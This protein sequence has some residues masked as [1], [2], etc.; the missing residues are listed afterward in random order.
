MELDLSSQNLGAIPTV[1]LAWSTEFLPRLAAA[2]IIL[3]GGMILARWISTLVMR[4]LGRATGLDVTVQPVITAVVRYAVVVLV[5]ILALGQLGVQ[6]A[7]LLAVLGAAGLAIGLSLQGTL[8]NIAAGIMLLWL[9]PFRVGDYIEV[10]NQNL[11]GTVREIGLFVCH[12]E[13]YDGVYLFAPN[14]T[15][16][17][18][19]LRNHSRAHARLVSLLV[20]LPHG[21]DIAVGTK[22]VQEAIK[23]M[24]Q[25]LKTPAPAIFVDSVTGDG[26]VLNC[27][28]W[29]KHETLGQVQRTIHQRIQ[30]KLAASGIELTAPARTARV[31]PTDTDPSRLILVDKS[32]P[33]D[34]VA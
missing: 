10:S 26:Y 24:P 25:V 16:W 2:M 27:R 17:N 20:T 1:I 11:A 31:V 19:S 29:T 12:L 15:I 34:S 7:S 32:E 13:T 23:S 18:F 22:A 14:A 21:A 3:I 28:V 8:T 5:L 4:V 30:D 6:T 33:V 9:R